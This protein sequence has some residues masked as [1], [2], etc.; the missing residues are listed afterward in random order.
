MPALP[1]GPAGGSQHLHRSVD[2]QRQPEHLVQF[3]RHRPAAAHEPLVPGDEP[4]GRT[5]SHG[6]TARRTRRAGARR[7]APA[8]AALRA[9]VRSGHER[10]QV[11]GQPALRVD[12]SRGQPRRR[13]DVGH[14]AGAIRRRPDTRARAADPAARSRA[15]AARQQAVAA[16]AA[17]DRQRGHHQPHAAAAAAGGHAQAHAPAGRQHR[18]AQPPVRAQAGFHLD[19]GGAVPRRLAGPLRSWRGV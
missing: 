6:R 16:A 18:D 11:R 7:A 4:A 10:L 1:A 12:A 15:H 5:R 3:A 14:R 13:P 19:A 8:A 17:P 2:D 9:R